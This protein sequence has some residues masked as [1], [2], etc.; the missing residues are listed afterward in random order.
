MK[1][2]KKLALGAAAVVVAAGAW[3]YSNSRNAVR[4]QTVKLERG[5]IRAS[6]AATGTANAMTTVQVGSL[7]SGN[8]KELYADFNTRVTKG[9]LVARIDPQIFQAKVD[10]ARAN[11]DNTRAGVASAEAGIE[12]ANADIAGAQAGLANQ[13]ANLVRAQSATRDA[14]V[15][16]ERRKTLANEGVLSKDDLDTAKATYDQAVAM[17]QAAKA[18]VDAAAHQVT[19]AQSQLKVAETQLRSAQAQVRQLTAQLE[20]AE[21]DLA[22]TEIRAPVDGIVIARRMDIGQTVAASFQAPTIFEIAQ[23]L[24]KMQVDTSVDEADIGRIKVGQPAVFTVDAY[25]NQT[26]RG[27]VGQIRQAPINVQ[28]VI[29]YDV[30][31]AVSNP[32]AK[33]LPGMTASVKMLVDQSENVLKVPN[34]AL[35]YRPSASLLKANSS[36]QAAGRGRQQP[37]IWVLGADGQPRAVKVELGLSDGSATAVNGADLKE[38][39]EIIISDTGAATKSTKTGPAGGGA[40][41]G[42]RRGGPGF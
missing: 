17:E 31:V 21:L 16:Y 33:L 8:I 13:Q 12:R 27:Q 28:N 15:K 4:F 19:S 2:Q 10:S 29:T 36:V 24:T 26:F 37:V 30:V 38:G 40:M 22:H 9:Q 34:S 6:V 11:L 5:A 23:D 39:D 1:H 42:G 14:T 32:E 18:Q 20:Q 25:P 35:R 3:W 41:G 7:V